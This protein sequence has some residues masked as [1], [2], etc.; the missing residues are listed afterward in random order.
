MIKILQRG[1]D[2]DEA[3][4]RNISDAGQ[5]DGVADEVDYV[6]NNTHYAMDE[7][8]VLTCLNEIVQRHAEH[9]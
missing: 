7:D 2:V 5:F 9:T 3:Y 6:I 4:R 8:T 1:D